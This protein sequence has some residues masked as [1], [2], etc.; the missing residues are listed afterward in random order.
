MST[1]LEATGIH[2]LNKS[3][4]IAHKYSRGLSQL[5]IITLDDE[6]RSLDECCAQWVATA[7]L[8]AH[9]SSPL[10]GEAC[11]WLAWRALAHTNQCDNAQFWDAAV[12]SVASR[13]TRLRSGD[14]TE[15]QVPPQL[16][17]A[18]CICNI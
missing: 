18:D 3:T 8:Y 16:L 7:F 2:F 4:G 1:K 5:D 13:L 15:G 9:V 14:L 6:L 17:Y 11:S 12:T 10:P